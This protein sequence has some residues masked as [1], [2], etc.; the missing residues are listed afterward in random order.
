MNSPVK[1]RKYYRE[2]TSWDWISVIDLK[3]AIEY[4]RDC[5][6]HRY[7]GRVPELICALERDSAA[8]IHIVHPRPIIA[9]DSH[10]LALTGNIRS[11]R[12]E[13]LNF[14]PHWTCR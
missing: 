3:R 9:V 7:T 11:L 4:L 13:T 12:I 2:I 1:L 10:G 8:H 6:E 14:D 5:C